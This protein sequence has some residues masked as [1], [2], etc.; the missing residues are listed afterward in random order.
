MSDL[1]QVLARYRDS[2]YENSDQGFTLIE[3]LIVIVLVPVLMGALAVMLISLFN[4]TV[5]K[6]PHGTAT[7]L[8]DS[9]DAQLA[10]AYFNRDVQGAKYITTSAS[11]LC[12]SAG[13]VG[14]Q[15][16]GLEWTSGSQTIDVSYFV[17][18]S[19]SQLIRYYCSSATPTYPATLS[20]PVTAASTSLISD[21][22]F[23]SVS[24]IA[25]GSCPASGFGAGA[26]TCANSGG[27]TYLALTVTC[28]NGSCPL[29]GAGSLA[30]LPG[31]LVHPSSPTGVGVENALLQAQEQLS[32]YHFSL[33]ASP[34][35]T[36][37]SAQFTN[38]NAG[39]VPP[40]II[41]G[42]ISGGNCNIQVTGAAAVNSTADG[43][44]TDQ[45]TGTIS[46]TGGIFTSDPN[47]S[48]ATS[49]SQGTISPT[50][51]YGTPVTPP[52]A[53]LTTPPAPPTGAPYVVVTETAS[54]WDPSTDP[55]VEIGGVLNNAVFPNGAIFI[56]TNGLKVS[57]NFSAPQGVLFYVTGG[58]VS[59]NG[60]GTLFLNPLSPNFE[61]P[62]QPLPELV[63]WQT[64]NGAM[65]LG[66]NG[67]TTVIN[68]AI[69][70]PNATT[71]LNGG[72]NSGGFTAQ[73]LDLGPTTCNGGD[74]VTV[75]GSSTGNPSSA[76]T[77]TPS[78]SAVA[79]NQPVT[80]TVMVNG[81]GSSTPA[82]TVT[83]YQC[84]PAAGSGCGQTTGWSPS[85]ANQVG[86]T[87]AMSSA[88]N[89]SSTGTSSAF[90]P[91]VPGTY[92]FAAYYQGTNYSNSS[93]LSKDSCFTVTA[94]APSAPT[95]TQPLPGCYG[96]GS[97]CGSWPG[98][99]KGL[100][101]DTGGPG[102]ASVQ[103]SILNTSNN[104][105]FDP[106]TNSFSSSG[107]KWVSVAVSGLGPTSWSY[108][109]PSSY[110]SSGNNTYTLTAQAVDTAGVIS[111]TTPVTFQKK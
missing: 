65:T 41:N 104:M 107:V 91:T 36:N 44:I 46:A 83:V 34:R 102:L 111:S 17:Q 54:N 97:G 4:N 90:T 39:G 33:T 9:H 57:K 66:G 16:L 48:G 59:L 99:I 22:V 100:A 96:T 47:P 37:P 2:R 92:C 80:A 69:Y 89:G 13:S 55:T 61:S 103:F 106:S 45:P 70:A 53:S 18:Q 40:L 10:S 6:D 79:I 26:T 110:F 58:S 95:V 21:N 32:S 67:N 19:P 76:T 23:G 82:G 60:N 85:V 43:S 108:S 84:G 88:G 105:Y 94:I 86:G 29:S 8:A 72:G 30:T 28:F 15:I 56:V 77:V 101:S 81:S 31:F 62:T 20:Y 74:S 73:A 52:Y 12:E 71:T 38:S 25:V 1:R 63:V 24:S 64:N 5:I 98:S 75:I 42:A 78:V 14:N 7:R 27:S 11:P 49:G 93:D 3:L 109:F 51:V 68:G 50:P 35:A 87:V